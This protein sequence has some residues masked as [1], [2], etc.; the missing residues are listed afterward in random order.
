MERYCVN[1]KK[2]TTNENSSVK[3]T[4]QSR[5]KFLS[6]CAVCGYKKPSS[7][8]IKN[9]ISPFVPNTPFLYCSKT[10]QSHKVFRGFQGVETGCIGNKWV[11]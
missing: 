1:Y 8:K 11:K 5:L 7:L 9:S 4:Q 2:N 3:K 6:N 10:S